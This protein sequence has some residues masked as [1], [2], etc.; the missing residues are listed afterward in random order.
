MRVQLEPRHRVA[1]GVTGLLVLCVGLIRFVY[2]P[3]IGQIRQHRVAV[4][5]LTVKLADA[6]GLADR[7]PEQEAALKRVSQQVDTINSRIGNSQALARVLDDLR[8]KTEDLHLELQATQPAQEPDVAR[9]LSLGTDLELR[10]V[11]LI[12]TLIGRSRNLGEF[13]GMFHDAPFLAEIR[14]LSVKTS[15]ERHPQLEATVNMVIY[16]TKSSLKL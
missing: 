8:A 1:L 16:L 9:G 6:S 15:P 5:D 10:E 12:V 13:L 3:V 11:P 14:Q 7:L 4:H 2:L